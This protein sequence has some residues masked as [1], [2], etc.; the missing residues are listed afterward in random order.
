MRRVRSTVFGLVALASLGCESRPRPVA[1]TGPAPSLILVAPLQV[2]G[3]VDPGL[4]PALDATAHLELG[5]RGYRSVPAAVAHNMLGT[6]GI[7]ADQVTSPESLAQ[8]RREY[9]VDAVLVREVRPQF[10]SSPER[11][12]VLRWQLVDAID[13]RRLWAGQAVAGPERVVDR[14]LSGP[15][16]SYQD[17]AFDDPFL[18][19][20]P[21]LSRE[22]GGATRAVRTRTLREQ[23]DDAQARVVERLPY[24]DG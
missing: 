21:V 15:R 5:K 6:L 23:A 11:A 9:A 22:L 14:R 7:A 8:L 17:D 1:L 3:E 12:F 16:G 2:E 20:E 13:Q 4:G 19:D 24:G 10:A 18:S